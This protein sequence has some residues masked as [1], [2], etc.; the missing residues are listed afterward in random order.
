MKYRQIQRALP[1][2]QAALAHLVQCWDCL[3]EAERILDTEVT[4][5]DLSDI[6]A[7]IDHPDES[8]HVTARQFAE[9]LN[10]TVK[11]DNP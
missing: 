8:M 4:V 5:G 6:A 7:R 2:L 9:W 3:N 10:F 11:S 1:H